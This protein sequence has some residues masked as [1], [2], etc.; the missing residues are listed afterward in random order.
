M[1]SSLKNILIIQKKS[2]LNYLI[3][4]YGMK[5]IIA[6]HEHKKLLDCMDLH[7]KNSYNFIN[8]L[9]E[10]APKNITIDIIEDNFLDNDTISDALKNNDYD[11]VF[12]L[13]GDG[14]FLRAA[15]FLN[16][17]DQLIVGVNTDDQ[18]STGYYCPL[19][20]GAEESY[21]ILH[22]LFFQ[23]EK[24]Q[25]RNLNKL[26]AKLGDKKVHFI[27]DLYFGEKFAGRVA[28]YQMTKNASRSELIKSSGIIVSTCSHL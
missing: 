14:T 8:Q 2:K 22:N 7:S 24:V 15:Q 16:K 17:D 25:I 10:I 19:H 11:S 20:P 28:K 6:S 26:E 18:H 9:K 21:K 23:P 5:A 12:S 27:N 1:K 3:D 13:G 4:K